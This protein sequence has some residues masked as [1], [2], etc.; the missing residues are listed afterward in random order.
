MRDIEGICISI[1]IGILAHTGYQSN[2]TALQ[3]KTLLLPSLAPVENFIEIEL[4]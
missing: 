1:C 3:L 4:S 2:T